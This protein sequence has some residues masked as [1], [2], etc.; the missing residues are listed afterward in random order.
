MTAI[1]VGFGL[2][3]LAPCRNPQPL[4]VPEVIDN[5]YPVPDELSKDSTCVH[6]PEVAECVNGCGFIIWILTYTAI[7]NRRCHLSPVIRALFVC[8]KQALDPDPCAV[9]VFPI[10]LDYPL[11]IFS[12]GQSRDNPLVLLVI[13]GIVHADRNDIAAGIADIST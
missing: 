3:H 5:A 9:A 6:V 4:I 13:R 8:W 2:A 7:F 10:L 11:D 1:C 12:A